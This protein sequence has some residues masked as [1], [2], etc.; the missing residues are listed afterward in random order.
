MGKEK[1]LA[2]RI[3]SLRRVIG[4]LNGLDLTVVKH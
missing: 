2:S 4:L 3:D 1:G